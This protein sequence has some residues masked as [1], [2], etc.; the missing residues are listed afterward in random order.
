M[1]HRHGKD[2]CAMSEECIGKPADHGLMCAEH[3]AEDREIERM[4]TDD[5]D[6]QS[7]PFMA[8]R[9]VEVGS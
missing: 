8:L 3:R 1:K 2:Q 6:P 4:F 5:V 7:R 9:A